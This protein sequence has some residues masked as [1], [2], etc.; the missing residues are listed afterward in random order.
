MDIII[1]INIEGNKQS[2]MPRHSPYPKQSPS[3]AYGLWRSLND[4]LLPSILMPMI[5]SGCQN[6][7]KFYTCQNIVHGCINL[8]ICEFGTPSANIPKKIPLCLRAQAG[9]ETTS[10]NFSNR[11]PPQ[12]IS[13][14]GLTLEP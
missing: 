8:N 12:S 3:A 11:R 10:Q 2:L 4:C 5:M 7:T 13:G 1:G 9:P 14:H 6:Y